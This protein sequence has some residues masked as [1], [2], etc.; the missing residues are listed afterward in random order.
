MKTV[1]GGILWD[2]L[3]SSSELFTSL[4]FTDSVTGYAVGNYGSILKTIDGGNSWIQQKPF[5]HGLSAV[6]FPDKN[7]GY[8]VAGSGNVLKT[9]NGGLDWSYLATGNGIPLNSVWFTDI[10][11]GYV[12]GRYGTILRT[13]SGGIEILDTLDDF[14]EILI[15]PNPV[16]DRIMIEI[17]AESHL[18]NAMVRIYNLE[19][20]ILLTTQAIDG[21]AEIFGAT[22]AS[23]MYIVKI[24]NHENAIATRFVKD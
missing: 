7:T 17:P 5:D 20:R 4:Y 2:V 19:G 1:D 12:V 18:E 6:F 8:A 21:K 23:G 3:F 9:T 15:Y 10:N 14:D 22:L 13:T 24:W 16:H 11:T